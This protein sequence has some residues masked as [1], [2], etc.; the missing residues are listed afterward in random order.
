MLVVNVN[1]YCKLRTLHNLVTQGVLGGVLRGCGKQLA[2][3]ITNVISFHVVGLPISL[4]LVYAAGMG[5]LGFWL[6]ATVGSITQ[7]LSVYDVKYLCCN[8]LQIT[9]G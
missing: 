9:N 6:G 2:T 8:L 1:E 7:V 3:A 4:T 5:A